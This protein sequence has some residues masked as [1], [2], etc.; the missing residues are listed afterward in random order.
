[1]IP[2][3]DREQDIPV[4]FQPVSEQ[5]NRVLQVDVSRGDVFG[6]SLLDEKQRI[7]LLHCATARTALLRR[8]PTL[9]LHP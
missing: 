6:L 7:G 1:M 2:F 9:V 4:E 3:V 5:V 8:I